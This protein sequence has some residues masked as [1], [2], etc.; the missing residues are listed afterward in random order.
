MVGSIESIGDVVTGGIAARAVEPLFKGERA[1]RHG[2][3]LPQLFAVVSA[4]G[5]YCHSCGQ[6]G[7]VHRTLAA[8]STICCTACCISKARSEPQSFPS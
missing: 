6:Q 2:A 7:H 4:I 5:D 3:D 8:L 1:Q